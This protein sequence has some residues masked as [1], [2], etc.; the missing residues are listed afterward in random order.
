MNADLLTRLAQAE[1]E[2]E[3]AWLV[4]E[5]LLHTL[6]P[7]LQ[8]MVWAAALPH[9]F[10]AEILAAL[11][12]EL[13]EAADALYSQLQQ[14]PFVEVFP[15][16]GYNIHERTRNT[17]MDRLWFSNPTEYRTLSE[18]ASHYF[19][20]QPESYQ[21]LEAL[22]HI[23]VAEPNGAADQLWDYTSDLNNTFQYV[24]LDV[25]TETL[26][27]H[28]AHH[29]LNSETE[30]VVYYRKGGAAKRIYANDEALANYEQ[31][32]GLFRDVGDRLG[33]ANTLKAIGDVLKFLKRNDEAL[34]SYEQANGLFRDVGSRLG[35]ANTLEAIGDV[36]KFLKRN[37]EA[38]A[39]Y[40]QANGLF[41]DVGD[42]L[43]E[44]NI[45]PELG[46]LRNNTETEVV[47]NIE[48]KDYKDATLRRVEKKPQP[49][50]ELLPPSLPT[51]LEEAI[52]LSILERP[53]LGQNI[54]EV[55]SAAS[56][57]TCQISCG[58][59]YPVLR[60]LENRGFI[61]SEKSE[62]NLAIRRGHNRCYYAV[63]D[64][65]REMLNN[66]EAMRHQ[67]KKHDGVLEAST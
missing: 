54:V 67:I 14:L 65:G 21:Q 5:H 43:G 28:A 45:F 30:A 33:E 12:P 52:M 3:R 58:T 4:T 23:A 57:G 16:R 59:L 62:V 29:R 2:D 20:Q 66:L 24:E 40:E 38:L 27:E 63:T 37:D 61:R 6:S 51:V 9:W 13:I 47:N 22:Y 35:E 11:R 39:N 50:K 32:I 53:R 18:R 60:R 49:L 44:A 36:L 26:L 64:Q 10:D 17:L 31:A 46:D 19:V 56:N 55:V 48:L 41:R 42:R 1:T 25:L 8:S 34:A 15:G 7:D